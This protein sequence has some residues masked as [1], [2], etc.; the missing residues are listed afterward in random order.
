MCT[1]I[2]RKFVL[3]SF[4]GSAFELPFAFDLSIS[5]RIT[6]KGFGISPFSRVNIHIQSPTFS[7]LSHL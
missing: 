5:S 2:E 4:A 3:G 1:N 6:E 7:Y